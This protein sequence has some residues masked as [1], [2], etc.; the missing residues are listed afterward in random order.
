MEKKKSDKLYHVP[1]F[2]IMIP[3]NEQDKKGGG[4]TTNGMDK[5]KTWY[6]VFM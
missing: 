3:K 2:I 6:Q 5:K 1:C 4:G